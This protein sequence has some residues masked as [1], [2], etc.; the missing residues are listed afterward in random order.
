MFSLLSMYPIFVW[1]LHES[2]DGQ[3]LKFED[4]ISALSKH[5]PFCLLVQ[6]SCRHPGQ[7][8]EIYS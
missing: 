8:R 2:F 5:P 1:K 7:H 3:G 4:T 6:L